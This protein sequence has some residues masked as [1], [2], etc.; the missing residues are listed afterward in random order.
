MERVLHARECRA[1]G[2]RAVLQLAVVVG[3]A[4]LY[5][6]SSRSR[7]TRLVAPSRIERMKQGCGPHEGQAAI[8][9]YWW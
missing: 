6:L 9:E 2:V 1:M 5:C 7:S 4:G 3:W 8:S